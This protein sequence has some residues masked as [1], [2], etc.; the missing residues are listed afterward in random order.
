MRIPQLRVGDVNDTSPETLVGNMFFPV[1]EMF[2]V[3]RGE[4]RRHPGF[5]M[6][7]IGDARDWNFVH[8]HAR[9][10]VFP[11]HLADFAMQLAHA[12]DVTAEPQRQDRHAEYV[13]WID[14]RLSETEQFVKRDAQFLGKWA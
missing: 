11:K 7:A 10:N 2:L 6:H 14:T 12:I 8:R 13:C 1:A 3:E 5:G 9:P 4:L